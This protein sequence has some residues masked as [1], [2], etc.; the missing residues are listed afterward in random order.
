MSFNDLKT[1]EGKPYSGMSIGSSHL[2]D[3]PNG[4]WE[5]TKLA[6]DKWQFVFKSIKS[7]KVA[8]PENSGVPLNT[9]YHWFI[10]AD[11]RV[12][13]TTKDVYQTIM[14]GAKFKMGHRRPYWK[15]WSYAYPGQLSY[16][17]RLIQIL[18]ETLLKLEQEEMVWL[19][20]E[21]FKD[22]RYNNFKRRTRLH[23]ES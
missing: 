22:I 14:E 21:S 15:N 6:P 11:Q 7:R 5:E 23:E 9:G 17:Q 16:R 19:E 13:K 10:M 4:T 8:A 20:K 3:Y 2:W 1:F 12:M 18:K